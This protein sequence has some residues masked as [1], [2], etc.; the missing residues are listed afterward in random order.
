M[1]RYSIFNPEEKLSERR[2]WETEIAE[3]QQKRDREQ[4]A[5]TFYAAFNYKQTKG[6]AAPLRPR[7]SRHYRTF[8][9]GV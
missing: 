4:I 9:Q 2:K 3:E 6:R 1:F 5:K 8:N 7:L